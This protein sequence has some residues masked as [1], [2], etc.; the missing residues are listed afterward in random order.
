MRTGTGKKWQGGKFSRNVCI[1]GLLSL[2]IGK[3]EAAT[4]RA[5]GGDGGWGNPQ[6]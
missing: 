6:P 4:S 3:E 1:E 5:V 2:S